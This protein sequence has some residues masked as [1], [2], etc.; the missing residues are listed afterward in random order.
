MTDGG[1]NKSGTDMENT[2]KRFCARFLS[3][4]VMNNYE[5]RCNVHAVL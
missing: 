3:D 1:K 2:N 5:H 4:N